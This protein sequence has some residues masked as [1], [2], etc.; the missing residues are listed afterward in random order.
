M[1]AVFSLALMFEISIPYYLLRVSFDPQDFFSWEKLYIIST[2]TW[3][4]ILPMIIAVRFTFYLLK[5]VS[6]IIK[7]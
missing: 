4:F 1:I 3:I 7:L 6:E 5:A 2:I